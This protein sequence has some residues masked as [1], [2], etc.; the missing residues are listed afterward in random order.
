MSEINAETVRSAIKN[1][2]PVLEALSVVL[3]EVTAGAAEALVE[4][5]EMLGHDAHLMPGEFLMQSMLVESEKT[6]QPISREDWIKIY[7]SYTEIKAIIDGN[8][9]LQ[10]EIVKHWETQ[11]ERLTSAAAK[12]EPVHHV[13]GGELKID[14]LLNGDF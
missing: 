13:A 4:V 1:A 11:E 9:D 5:L 7:D 2:D 14:K 8:P 10:G 6:F 3:K 12:S